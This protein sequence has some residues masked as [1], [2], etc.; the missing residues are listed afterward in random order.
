[1]ILIKLLGKPKGRLIIISEFSSAIFY[2]MTRY[3]LLTQISGPA[4]ELHS[5]KVEAP[6]SL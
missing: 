3:E 4:S 1:M 5:L 2:Q 6:I